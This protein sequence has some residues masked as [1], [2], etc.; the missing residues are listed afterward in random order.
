MEPSIE[1]FSRC[2]SNLTNRFNCVFYNLAQGSFQSFCST[3]AYCAELTPYGLFYVYQD[4][5]NKK[6]FIWWATK[7]RKIPLKRCSLLYWTPI[8]NRSS[9]FHLVRSGIKSFSTSRLKQNAKCTTWRIFTGG[10]KLMVTILKYFHSH[11]P[12]GSKRGVLVYAIRS[13]LRQ[14]CS[15]H[16]LRLHVVG[17]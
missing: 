8:N 17:I 6:S 12:F 10:H 1:K 4:F 7:H 3:E 13:A 9:S 5:T 14:T 11:I 2:Y 16:Q 15:V